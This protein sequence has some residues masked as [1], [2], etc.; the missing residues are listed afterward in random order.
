MSSQDVA[1]SVGIGSL[2]DEVASALA[3]DVEYRL[4]QVIE[5]AVKF[6][7]HG[8][9]T[10]LTTKDVD[11]ALKTKNIDPLW[12]FTSPDPPAF[13]KVAVPN[14]N[15]YFVDDEEVDLSKVLQT[16]LPPIPREVSYTGMNAVLSS[17]LPAH[18]SVMA[19]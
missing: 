8:K 10:K 1:E 16:P 19:R 17:F 15:V 12:G 3:G 4:H 9:R 2:P 13:R 18:T 14:G 11:Y 7:N 6:M 5:E